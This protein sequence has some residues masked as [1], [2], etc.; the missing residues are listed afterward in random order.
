L[1]VKII[2]QNAPPTSDTFVMG[3]NAIQIFYPQEFI[4]LIDRFYEKHNKISDDTREKF[5]KELYDKPLK[6][7]LIINRDVEVVEEI[8]RQ[9]KSFF[10]A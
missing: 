8:V 3:N 10:N 4:Q 9:I 1:G 2:Q 5:A 6:I 7:K